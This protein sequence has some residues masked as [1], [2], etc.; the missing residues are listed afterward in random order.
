M[1]KAFLLTLLLIASSPSFTWAQAVAEQNQE[2]Q[3]VDAT[4]NNPFGDEKVRAEENAMAYNFLKRIMS[5]LEVMVKNMYTAFAQYA[6]MILLLM[7]TFTVIAYAFTLLSGKAIPLFD[8]VKFIGIVTL[9]NH[10][11]IDW[12]FFENWIYRPAMS[13]MMGIP[14]FIV[15]IATNVEPPRG[16]NHL[17]GIFLSFDRSV[18]KVMKAGQI[19]MDSKGFFSGTFLFYVYGLGLQITFFVLQMVFTYVFVV[20]F[21]S[22]HILLVALPFVLALA[23]FPSTRKYLRNVSQNCLSF[24]IT[25]AMA[26]LSMSLIIYF[27]EGTANEL[28]DA[29]IKEAPS[30]AVPIMLQAF[31]FGIISIFLQLKATSYAAQIVGAADTGFGQGF[32]AMFAVAAG[33][34]KALW[35]KGVAGAAGTGRGAFGMNHNPHTGIPGAVGYGAGMGINYSGKKA[36][37][38][39]RYLYGKIKDSFG[40]RGE[41]A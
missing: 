34:G 8:V 1:T 6:S 10:F 26:A 21:V 2:Q 20:A 27:V 32:G 36:A 37:K 3:A 30:K 14:S 23:A 15:K 35:A 28:F 12:H 33:T 16:L 13:I 19:V 22:I 24:M 41:A 11:I 38:G 17:E 7:V 5:V 4:Q 39:S 40:S 25:P 31:F 9:I 29:V 18:G